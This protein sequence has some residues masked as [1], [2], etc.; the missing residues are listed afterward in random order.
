MLSRY[1]ISSGELVAVAFKGR[2]YTRFF[3]EST[4]GY[5]TGNSYEHVTNDL[6]LMIS[7]DVFMDRNKVTY[8][9]KVKVD[10]LIEFQHNT[11]LEDDNQVNRAVK[12]L[13]E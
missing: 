6:I 11:T 4:A 3:G 7:E 1:T 10:E 12:W 8:H 9:N 5:T 13:N 2:P